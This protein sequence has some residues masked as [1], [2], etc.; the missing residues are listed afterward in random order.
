MNVFIDTNVILEYVM[1]REKEAVT[2]RMFEAFTEKGYSLYISAGSFY[3]ILYILSKALKKDYEIYGDDNLRM[4]RI[5]MRQI[6]QMFKVAD[7]D[8]DSLLEGIN[9]HSFRDLE[10]SCQYQLAITSGCTYLIT[11]N[12][13][14]YPIND[15]ADTSVKVISPEHYPQ[16]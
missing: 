4:V 14:D 13:A 1:H 12:T 15:E 9:N 3:T 16:L 8:N 5:L 11:F 10:D 2:K 6:L 7:H